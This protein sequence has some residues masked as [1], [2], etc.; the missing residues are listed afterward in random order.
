MNG[1]SINQTTIKKRQN[2]NPFSEAMFK[3]L[4]YHPRFPAVSKFESIKHSRVWCEKF[5]KWYNKQ[6]LHS[7]LKFITPENRHNGKEK[8]ILQK[9]HQVYQAARQLTPMRWS[10]ETRNWKPDVTVSLNPNR[11]LN[12]KQQNAAQTA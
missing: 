3:T 6:H 5:V 7:A 8:I 11:K 9:R 1:W 12:K 10:R 2:D 4:K